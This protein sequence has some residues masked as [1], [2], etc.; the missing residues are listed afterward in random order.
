LHAGVVSRG[1]TMHGR[2]PT[3]SSTKGVVAAAH[4]L[5]AQAGAQ[6]L[7]QGGNAFDAAAATAAALNVV[8][9]YMSGLAGA[10]LATCWIA[11]EKRIKV[12]DF[13]P[14]VPQ[15][16]P[17][18]RFSKREDLVRGAVSAGVPGNLAGWAELVRAHGNKPLGDALV[19]ATA[20]ARD[21]FPLVEF[22][23]EEFNENA[24][25]LKAYEVIYGEF[26]RNYM[27]GADK[28]SIGRVPKQPDLAVTFERLAASGP[29][30]LYGGELGA[31]IIAHLQKLGG[32]M[33][34]SDLE[35]VA[36]RWKDP[37]AVSYR[38]RLV[39]VP[40]P[41][42][43][44]FQFL[45]T[46]R[47]LEGFDLGAL[48]S[49][50]ADHLDIVCRAVRLAAGVRISN[51][52]PSPQ[53]VARLL[54]QDHV[55]T[56]RA[57]VRDGRPVAGPTEQ[58]MEGMGEDPGHTTSMSIGDR[59]GNLICLTQSLGSPFGSGVVVP[60]TGVC[61]N[62]FL[63]WAEVN[64]KSPNRTAPGAEL[65]ICMAPTIA[66][67]DGVPV[68]ALG[69]PG[70]YGILQTQA[71]AY[72]QHVDFGLALQDAIEAPRARLWDGTLVQVEGRIDAAVIAEL[73]RRGHGAEAFADWTM[74]VGGMQAVAVDPATGV[75]TGGADPRRDGYAV[76][77]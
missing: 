36:P 10:G 26:S 73:K 14:R 27:G 43:E 64:P 55:E 47:I 59:E 9:P 70:S 75:M 58:W 57:R 61:L 32:Y 40:P 71:Q 45:L 50:G 21:G 17:V 4:P 38:G 7:A 6:M 41:A 3:I 72:V 53:E 11:A 69:T 52:N 5:A 16:F 19:S 65:P 13:V 62:N 66:T 46:L 49:N 48:E 30:L 39:H 22:N 12:L 31:T 60:G 56:L 44:G 54:D 18:A 68:L 34:M 20:L 63:Y 8:E 33:T 74:K 23:V 29:Q 24:P 35:Q 2:R 76:A 37:I 28:V 15:S 1:I 25:A 77:L 67:R 51:N 42:C